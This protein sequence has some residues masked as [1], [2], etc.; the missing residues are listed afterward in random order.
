MRVDLFGMSKGGTRPAVQVWMKRAI[1][2]GL[3][4][5]LSYAVTKYWSMED[6]P[7]GMP[8]DVKQSILALEAASASADH[9]VGALNGMKKSELARTTKTLQEMASTNSSSA[10]VVLGYCY[11]FGLGVDR[12]VEKARLLYKQSANEGLPVGELSLGYWYRMYDKSEAGQRESFNWFRKAAERGLPDAKASLARCYYE[13]K[14]VHPDFAEAYKWAR[15]AVVQTTNSS[16][17]NFYLGRCYANGRGV[18]QD[19]ALAIICF[20]KAA[21]QGVAS[22]SVELAAAYYYGRGVGKDVVE[23]LVWATIARDQKHPTGAELVAVFNEQL[24]EEQRKVAMRRVQALRYTLIP[25]ANRI[26]QGS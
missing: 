6:R 15:R 11:E 4:V 22:A 7:S 12:D 20:R 1:G 8:K 26:S 24:T 16:V 10:K 2:I 21:E 3:I 13:G 17:A 14:G 23:A 19:P 9:G 18:K 5:L 25:T